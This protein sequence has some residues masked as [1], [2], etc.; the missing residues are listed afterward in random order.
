VET[1]T[2]QSVEAAAT[3]AVKTTAASE[4]TAVEPA[5]AEA[6]TPAMETTPSAKA[7]ASAVETAS[8]AKA[9]AST[10]ARESG[11]GPKDQGQQYRAEV[12]CSPHT[13][14]LKERPP[15]LL[16]SLSDCR[17]LIMSLHRAADQDATWRRSGRISFLTVLHFVR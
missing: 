9:T 12:T 2:S 14:L 6:T 4:A 1:T 8:T 16:L 13:H 3:K 11:R 10:E 15:V 7:T 5:A 17:F